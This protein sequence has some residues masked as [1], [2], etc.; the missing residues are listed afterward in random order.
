MSLLETRILHFHILQA[1]THA[2]P[3]THICL[4]IEALSYVLLAQTQLV[5]T[6]AAHS[7][8]TILRGTLATE[9]KMTESFVRVHSA[10]GQSMLHW[11]EIVIRA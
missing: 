8:S 6:R 10:T 2:C 9:R 7:T 1:A 3:P 5:I 4:C 11:R